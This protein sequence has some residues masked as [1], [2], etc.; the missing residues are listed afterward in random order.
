[1]LR[2]LKE[3]A[4]KSGSGVQTGRLRQIKR[5]DFVLPSRVV[6]LKP[7]F[8]T[9]IFDHVQRGLISSR[10]WTHLLLH[11]PR[12]GWPLSQVTAFELLAGVH[13]AGSKGF[14]Q[15]RRRIEIAYDLSKGRVLDDP[16]MISRRGVRAGSSQS[17]TY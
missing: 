7:I 13:F 11:R 9:N 14:A 4:P 2:Q 5:A 8:D 16:R 3:T 12:R 6:N 15:V 17:V 1:M 10:D